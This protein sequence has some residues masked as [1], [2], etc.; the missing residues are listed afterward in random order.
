MR[1]SQ[2]YDDGTS[3]SEGADT[4]DD[5]IFEM[6]LEPAGP[7]LA[8]PMRQAS[9]D[10]ANLSGST[11]SDGAGP[12]SRTGSCDLDDDLS[13]DGSLPVS[14]AGIVEAFQRLEVDRPAP[15]SF[16]KVSVIGRGSYGKVLL[17]KKNCGGDAGQVFAMKVLKKARIVKSKTDIRHTNAERDI[18]SLPD[19]KHPFVIAL[20]YAF[21][22]ESMLYLVLQYVGG[23]DLFRIL[24]REGTL[25]EHAARFYVCELICAL[26]HI[27]AV[28]VVY[29]DLKPENILLETSGHIK[30][31]DFGL[32]KHL[33]PGEKTRTVC[34]TYEYMAPEIVNKTG[35]DT[36]ADYW[37]LGALLYDMTT[38]G[39]PFT[40]TNRYKLMEQITKAELAV[41]AK[42]TRDLVSLIGGLMNRSVQHRLGSDNK[43]GVEALKRHRWF[44]SVD[45]GAVEA[46]GLTPPFSPKT[47]FPADVSNFDDAF[48]SQ[49]VKDTPVDPHFSDGLNPFEDF[50][51][52]PPPL[53]VSPPR[54]EYGAHLGSEPP[55]GYVTPGSEPQSGYATPIA[56]PTSPRDSPILVNQTHDVGGGGGGGKDESLMG[57][58]YDVGGGGGNVG[59]GS[60]KQIHSAPLPDTARSPTGIAVSGPGADNW[61]LHT[62]SLDS[63]HTVVRHSSP[64][65]VPR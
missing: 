61:L 37:S 34:G 10:G 41:P 23:G 63:K 64:Q 56:V 21:Q 50:S 15:T 14:A 18:L 11:D 33:A 60:P 29:R 36:L 12:A 58:K 5:A 27:H 55:S 24:D 4:D 9:Q 52:V 40:A 45:W 6:E 35:H 2:G 20:H 16:D 19:I 3:T 1:A 42:L 44:D 46:W 22:T 43:G 31:T 32:A 25:Q 62:S 48:T 38:G 28:G 53:A 7:A 8:V 30:L 13:L 54:F 17:V 47:F 49:Q 51:Y 59:N 57:H 39:P 65:I 26:G